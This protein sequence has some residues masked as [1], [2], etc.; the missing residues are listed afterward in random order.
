[1]NFRT[2]VKSVPGELV[3]VGYRWETLREHYFI[4]LANWEKASEVRE[5]RKL[6]A[7]RVWQECGISVDLEE[8]F[9]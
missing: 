3:F 6:Y 4:R 9:S 1:M 7:A 8:G 5:L 2:A